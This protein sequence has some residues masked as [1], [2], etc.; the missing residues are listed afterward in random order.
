MRL[1]FLDID[2][3]LVTRRPC[4]MEETLG[5]NSWKFFLHL[6]RIMNEYTQIHYDTLYYTA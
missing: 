4:V 5:G 3:V 2:G 6:Y 1:I